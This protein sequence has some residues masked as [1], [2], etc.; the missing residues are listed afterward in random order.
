MIKEEV[1]LLQL[2]KESQFP[3]SE[4]INWKCVDFDILFNEAS[5]QAVFGL[6]IPL[7]PEEYISEKWYDM[8]LQQKQYN[9]RYFFSQTYLKNLLDKA[10]IPF[11]ILKGSAAAINYNNP[12]N[13]SMGDIDF[14]VPSELFNKTKELLQKSGFV[15][16]KLNERH[17]SYSMNSICFELHHHFSNDIDVDDIISDGLSERL[18]ASIEGYD[19]PM[20]SKLANGLVLLDHMRCH[21]KVSLGLRQVIDWMMFVYHNLDDEFWKNEFQK[22]A[23]EKGMDRLAITATR[24]CQI[25]LGLPETITWCR[26]ADEND[27]R[28]LIECVLSS[29]NF[30]RKNGK[31]KN[32]EMVSTNIKRYGL[33]TWL[34][35]AGEHNWKA[36]QNHHWLRPFCWFYQLFRYAKQRIQSG[37]KTTSIKADLERSNNRYELLK[38]LGIE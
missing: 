17:Q 31:G 33:F 7:I 22:V 13:R 26:N 1:V 20:L 21:L 34:Q 27:C 6:V 25:Y 5:A 15:V 36:Y 12:M 3:I 18:K 38:R 19:F 10:K 23:E 2:I 37:R 14:I 11:V 8:Y 4:D 28:M 35:I 9:I 32:V 30:G 16:G 24:T 29:G